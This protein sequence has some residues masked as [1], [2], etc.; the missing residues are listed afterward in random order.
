MKKQLIQ[1]AFFATVL[2]LVVVT[3][4]NAQK[5]KNKDKAAFATGASVVT[6]KAG[7]GTGQCKAPRPPNRG[8]KIACKPCQVPVCE[9]GKW[10]YETIEIDKD[11]CRPR[12]ND[13]GGVCTIGPT[14]FCPPECKKC[15]RQ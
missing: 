14:D 9:D 8:C 6:T 1:F 13:D 4:V 10:V 3:G 15:V 7:N 12:P 11:Q 2:A 5:G